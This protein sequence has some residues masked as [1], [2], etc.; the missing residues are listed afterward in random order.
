VVVLGAVSLLTDVSSEM[1]FSLLPA[2]LAA[3]FPAAPLVLGAMEG[4]AELVSAGL[5]LLSGRW[6]DRARSLRRLVI[7]GYALSGAARP[8]MAVV[9]RWWQPLLVRAADRVG[10]GIRTSPRDALIAGW[11]PEGARARAY[12]FH[13]GMDHLGAAIGAGVAMGLVAFGL[14][15]EQVFLASAIPGAAGVAALLLAKD[16]APPERPAPAA[17]DRARDLEPLPRSLWR[18]LLPVGVFGLANATDAF[19]LLKLSE[20]GASAAWLPLSW[21]LLH[22][23]KAAVSYPAG[24]LADRL[25][26]RRLVVAGW[27]LYATSYAGLALSPSWR[28]TV[29]AIAFYGLYHALAEGAEKALLVELVPPGARGRAFG[30]Y[31]ALVGASALV[32]GLAFGGIWTRWRSPAAFGGA[33]GAALLAVALLVALGPRPRGSAPIGSGP[34]LG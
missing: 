13:R 18:Y 9:A 11:V 22:V 23:V 34:A 10:K 15:P 26:P 28:F 21:L 31:H 32:A 14:R 7:A 12:G 20:Q 17:A 24:W 19:L 6:A 27:V 25:G 5:K 8:L 33:G 2:F 3:R 16:P 30:L 4:L 29:A 1:I